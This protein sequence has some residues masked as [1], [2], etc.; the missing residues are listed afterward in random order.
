MLDSSFFKE[1]PKENTFDGQLRPGYYDF[2]N[3]TP[4]STGT[5]LIECVGQNEL[6]HYLKEREYTPIETDGD[7]YYM[8]SKVDEIEFTVL[9]NNIFQNTE[10]KDKDRKLLS[11]CNGKD[12]I[13][14]E[15]KQGKECMCAKL[16]AKERYNVAKN[17]NQCV[18]VVTMNGKISGLDDFIIKYVNEKWYFNKEFNKLLRYKQEEF[19]ILLKLVKRESKDG[20]RYN[21]VEFK[22]IHE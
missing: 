20:H 10:T 15:E 13:W 5:W 8:D 6:L 14:P 4:G 3:K 1:E 16:S 22:M 9:K 12:I 21:N 2:K 17:F 7:T 11:K 18:P 19:R